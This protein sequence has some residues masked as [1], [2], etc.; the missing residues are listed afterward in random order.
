M[1]IHI[2]SHDVPK[3]DAKITPFH[4]EVDESKRYLLIMTN[5]MLLLF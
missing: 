3:H 2:F 5:N 4:F 1:K